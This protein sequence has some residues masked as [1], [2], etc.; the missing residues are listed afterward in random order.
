MDEKTCNEVDLPGNFNDQGCGMHDIK[1][2]SSRS[3]LATGAKNPSEIVLFRLPSI[4]P[5][6]VLTGHEDWMFGV[7]FIEDDLVI[8]GSRDNHI[9]LWRFSV[10]DTSVPIHLPPLSDRL[11]HT[12]RVRCLRYDRIKQKVYSLGGEGRLNVWSLDYLTKDAGIVLPEKRENVCLAIQPGE[13]ILAVGSQN[14]IS[15][16]DTKN[17]TII[18]QVPSLNHDWGIRSVSFNEHILTVGGGANKISFFDLRKEAYMTINPNALG[19]EEFGLP[20]T[21]LRVVCGYSFCGSQYL[22]GGSR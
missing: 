10:Q 7:D 2:N 8:S 4:K 20:V 11:A 6:A 13:H 15:L 3:I 16:I 22:C 9:R 18:N 12:D 14:F 21:K 17:N 1:T 19:Y 5:I